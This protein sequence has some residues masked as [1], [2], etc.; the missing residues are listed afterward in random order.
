MDEGM[1]QWVLRQKDIDALRE[2]QR[3]GGEVAERETARATSGIGASDGTALGYRQPGGDL[4]HAGQAGFREA[5]GKSLGDDK[6][7]I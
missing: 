7:L 5:L 4:P 1:A 3:R 2:E 6:E